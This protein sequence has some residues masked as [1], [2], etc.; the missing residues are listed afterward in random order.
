MRL[1]ITTVITAVIVVIGIV[2]GIGIPAAQASPRIPAG[3]LVGI[4]QVCISGAPK[5]D[6]CL[7]NWYAVQTNA[8]PVKWYGSG[9]IYNDW[10][11]YIQGTVIGANCGQPGGRQCWPFITGSGQNAAYN[12]DIVWGFTW[13]DAE[14]GELTDYCLDSGNYSAANAYGYMYIWKCNG[15]DNQDFIWDTTKALMLSVG[16][17]NANYSFDGFADHAWLGCAQ[18]NCNDGAGVWVGTNSD[19]SVG[20]KYEGAA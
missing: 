14:A 12:G 16:A 19:Y 6:Q 15:N 8:N 10:G 2:T 18:N 13:Y 3:S 20:M 4:R 17:V 9:A 7:N 5:P 11:V 1:R